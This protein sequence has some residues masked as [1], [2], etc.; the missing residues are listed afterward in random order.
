MGNQQCLRSRVT[1]WCLVSKDRSLPLWWEL[2][3]GRNGGSR[4]MNQEV[5]AIKLRDGHGVHW[6]G[7]SKWWDSQSIPTSKCVAFPRGRAFSLSLCDSYS[8]ILTGERPRQATGTRRRTGLT[9]G[10]YEATW[11]SGRPWD[12]HKWLSSSPALNHC[13]QLEILRDNTF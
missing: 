7:I 13:A 11:V 5:T 4:E 2:D 3:S 10:E 6:V 8:S 12:F 9:P 1:V